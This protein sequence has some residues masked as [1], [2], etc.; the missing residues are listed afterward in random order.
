MS[1]AIAALFAALRD[2]WQPRIL[3]LAVLP[4]LAAIAAWAGL[5]WFFASDWAQAVDAWIAHTSWLSWVR[6]WGLSWIVVWVGE[7]G[8]IALMLPIVLIAAVL[9]TDVLA[10]PV[11]VPFIGGQ[12][13]PRLEKRRGGTV[14]G[15]LWNAVVAIVVFVLL[16]MVSLPLWFTGIGALLLPPL[17]SAYFNQRMFRY[18]ALAEHADAAEYRAI[19]R[20]AGGRLYLLGLLLSILLWVP[21]VNLTVPVLSA[22]AFTHLGLAELARL[23]RVTGK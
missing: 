11:I 19:L 15:S 2:F 6:D 10:M 17:I 13:Y 16:W 9:V 1:P 5:A 4:P 8:A 23:R 3:A 12:H 21:L 18:D 14:A 22:L 7:I 20:D